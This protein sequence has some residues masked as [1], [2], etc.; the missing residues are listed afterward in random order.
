[1][2]LPENIHEADPWAADDQV[3]PGVYLAK[4]SQAEEKTSS[5]GHPMIVLTW[6]I[7][8]GQFM[9]AELRDWV[10]IT[11]GAAGKVVALLQYTGTPIP[12]DG[13]LNP[14]TLIGRS[15][16]IVVRAEDYT[17]RETGDIKSSTKV[18]G[19]KPT[20]ERTPASDVTGP[21]D[22]AAFATQGAGT[23]DD[24]VPF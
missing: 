3:Q 1:M 22:T 10:V 16:L 5:G 4:V 18:K 6:R 20:S 24:D 11:E 13:M 21:Q 15:A 9:G 17:D 8:D 2:K 23:S 14:R 19:Y 7:E 12:A